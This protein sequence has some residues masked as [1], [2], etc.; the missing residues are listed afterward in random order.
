MVFPKDVHKRIQEQ[1]KITGDNKV[2]FIIVV[3]V[4]GNA[5]CFFLINFL[6]SVALPS[7]P[8]KAALFV[9]LAVM[10][11]MGV[12]VFRFF[13]FDEDEKKKEY[14]GQQSDSFTKYM[15]LRKDVHRELETG[16]GKVN[17]FEFSDGTAMCVAE[18]R[19]GSNDDAR[20]AGTEE[21]YQKMIKAVCDS[22]FEFR[23]IIIP[24]NFRS[25]REFNQHIEAVNGIQDPVLKQTILE[26]T[27]SLV[28][29][30]YRQS[31]A[32]VVYLAVRA[33]SNYQHSDLET[34]IRKIVDV[35]YSGLNA[36]RCV[37]FLDLGQLLEFYREFYGI[38][39][40]DLAMMRTIDLADDVSEDFSRVV[41]L[42]SLKSMEDKVYKVK[43]TDDMFRIKEHEI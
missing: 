42:Y 38:A 37:T 31:N 7:M 32:D 11:V 13:I 15:Y 36:F 9:Q 43:H 19:F 16:S 34:V 5:A 10:A 21:L 23:F 4:I 1:N 20:A 8:F 41:Q 35:M 26:Y 2:Q 18:F 27:D 39:A 3:F 40:I 30:S 29:M 25:S 28:E 6:F 24:E 12:M 17:A 22:G 14:K 33:L